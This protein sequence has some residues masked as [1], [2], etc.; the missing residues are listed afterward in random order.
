MGAMGGWAN[1]E[2]KNKKVRYGKSA[3][4]H[5]GAM[6][7]WAEAE[8]KNKKVRYGKSAVRH[9]GAMGGKNTS[10]GSEVRLSTQ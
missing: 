9:M 1:A 4:R 5:M 8:N 10:I 2:N 3:V 7:G 6:G